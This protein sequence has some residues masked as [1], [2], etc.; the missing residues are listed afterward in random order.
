MSTLLVRDLF[1]LPERIHK[2]DFVLKLTE[3]LQ[4]A[5]ET[6]KT[7]VATASLADAFDGAL[8]LI[9]GALAD[10]RSRATYLHGS[11]GS[12][13]SHFMAI[14]SLLLDGY[15]AAW[16]IP[17]LHALRQKHAFVGQKRLLQLQFHMVGRDSI[18]EAVFGGY[19]AR[20]R[21]L[22]PKAT[23]PG[24]FAD[25]KLF[26][27]ARG[28]LEELGDTAFFA[29]MNG[30]ADGD[31]GELGTRW[32]RERFEM[33]SRSTELSV[34]EELFSALVTTRFKAYASESRAFIDLDTGLAVM[35]RH[36]KGLGYDAIV[37]FLDELILWLSHKASEVSWLHGEVQKMVKLV[38][39]QDATRLV[40]I[41]SFIARQRSLVE[42]VGKD[43]AGAEA[44]RLNDSL[45]HWEGR[46]GKITLED[47][48]LPAIIEQ[49]VLRRR[50]DAAK[51]TLDQAFDQMQRT[52]GAS[53]QTLL[54]QDDA[55]SFRKLYP[56]SPALVEALVALSNSLQR[57]R[58]AIRLLMELLVEH[59]SDLKVGEIVRVGDLF[60]VLAGGE[61]PADGVMKARFEA[62]KQVYRYQFLPMIQQQ[63]G[64][65]TAERCQR[66]RPGHPT[67]IGCSGCTE[68]QCRADNRILKTLLIASLVPEVPVF[69]DLT[70]SR[71]AQVN[72]GTLKVPIPGTEARL[73]AQRLKSWASEKG[74]LHVGNQSDPTV[75][76]QLEGVELEPI[77]AQARDADSDGARQRLIRDLLFE[78]MGVD[79][80]ADWGKDHPIT[81]WKTTRL[82]H[83]RFGNVR[84]MGSEQLC[85][86]DGHDWRLVVDY[87]FDRPNHGPNEDLEVL[88]RFVEEGKGSWTLVWLPHFF[89]ATINKLLGE[90]VILDHILEHSESARRYVAHLSVENQGRALLD[91]KNLRNQ[92]RNRVQQ[93]LE[94]AYGVAQ[95]REGDLDSEKR[96]PR[97]LV[98]L[99]A[100]VQVRLTLAANLEDALDGYIPALLEA[101][102]PRH[103][104]F[105][106]P[107]TRARVERL[108]ER[109]GD[110]VDA[111]EKRIPADK[112]LEAEMRGTLGE[113]GLVRTTEGAVHL[114]EDQKLQE[115][116]N[117][118]RRKAVDEPT[119]GEV[120]RW[121]DE[122]GRMGLETDALD[123]VVRCYAR[124]AARTL[125]QFDKP[126]RPAASKEI[127]DEV[128][129]EKPDLPG[130]S[131]WSEALALFGTLFGETWAGRALHADNLKLFESKLA[132][133]LQ[134]ATGPAAK[135]P[136]V[137][138]SRLGEMGETDGAD[139]LRTALSGDQICAALVGK[140][141]VE[142]VRLL[143]ACKPATSASALAASLRA[144]AENVGILEDN[145]VFGVFAQ[146]AG[147]RDTLTSAAELLEQVGAALRQDEVIVALAPR[148]RTLAEQGQQ[149]LRP[150]P[151][152]E[153]VV[154]KSFRVEAQGRQAA[155]EKLKELLDGLRQTIESASDEVRLTGHLEVTDKKGR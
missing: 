24:L 52:A 128:V 46:Y 30:D 70:A 28:M 57:E 74:Q 113:L 1:D 115:L 120:R 87:P 136:R 79:K 134:S 80:V 72:H 93:A 89:S 112:A 98:V 2:G 69:K 44:A 130:H 73:V 8:G 48:N 25:E 13:K 6:A 65:T 4:H 95:E 68:A 10:G 60:D 155:Q 91:L 107:L 149:L 135:L 99:K 126:Y 116:E 38:E 82:G 154:L 19:M 71:L 37:L 106:E 85:C 129:L 59:I 103:P 78:S 49:R 18:E 152:P 27:D 148:L 55:S 66:E 96:V 43:Y 64:T 14:L 11:F 47:S 118:R 67:R 75:R 137:L 42:M 3:G 56:F 111:Q 138:G 142:Q 7:Y 51:V 12:G 141:A 5:D 21:Q 140:P 63:N 121:I 31:W 34:R 77:L 97:H 29:P 105:T 147:Q 88:D 144:A 102:Y 53:W 109:F 104:R 125:M 35:A 133:K 58:T 153:G 127:P 36:A 146:L 32:D 61:D 151:G 124:W 122:S 110:L 143:A 50:N 83:V 84:T 132:T 45:K 108:V 139:R 22:H 131:E 9:G 114:L 119:V 15:E 86:P 92:K 94:Q 33:A 17:E 39:A 26:E 81:W 101:R 100:G 145:L 41:V 123:L 20:V 76:L 117:T 90:L 150:D 54:G 40:P 16:R 62:A 23:I